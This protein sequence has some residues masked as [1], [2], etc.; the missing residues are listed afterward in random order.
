MWT[1]NNRARYDRSFLRY[2]SD[3]T[4]DEWALVE[5]LI[6]PAKR[7][8]DKRTVIMREVVTASC[9]FCRQVASGVRFR[10]TCRRARPSMDI[11][12]CGAGMAR[13]IASITCSM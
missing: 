11:S 1:T 12:T 6:P 2:P 10:K 5:P 9:I 7:G 13:S 3:L 4:D 8:G